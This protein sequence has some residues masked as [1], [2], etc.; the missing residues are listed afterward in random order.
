MNLLISLNTIY[1]QGHKTINQTI[2][3]RLAQD[4][5]LQILKIH[6]SR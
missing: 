4:T 3:T 1:G 6:I 5:S 2:T